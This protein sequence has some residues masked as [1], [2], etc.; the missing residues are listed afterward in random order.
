MA[1]YLIKEN[2]MLRLIDDENFITVYSRDCRSDDTKK[3]IGIL[4]KYNICGGTIIKLY[5]VSKRLKEFQG[6]K[7]PVLM[8]DR[9]VNA[10]L[11]SNGIYRMGTS[12]YSL[13]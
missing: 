6:E 2:G 5:K 7:Y 11:I 3:W 4:G 10:D 13:T 9:F 1:K 12:T 8:I